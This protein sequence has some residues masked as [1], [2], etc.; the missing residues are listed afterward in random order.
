MIVFLIFLIGFCVSLFISMWLAGNIHRTEKFSSPRPYSYAKFYVLF[1]ILGTML[2]FL[3]IGFY[4]AL[5][6]E[7]VPAEWVSY[8]TSFFYLPDFIMH[9]LLKRSNWETD[10]LLYLTIAVCTFT[11]SAIV[12]AVANTWHNQTN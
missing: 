3:R 4:M 7:L 1:L 10:P 11:F 9:S 2:S 6:N 8:T 12:A 5:I